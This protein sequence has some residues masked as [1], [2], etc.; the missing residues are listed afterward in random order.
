MKKGRHALGRLSRGQHQEEHF[1]RQQQQR[2]DRASINNESTNA[3]SSSPSRPDASG[4]GRSAYLSHSLCTEASSYCRHPGRPSPGQPNQ[5]SPQTKHCA[6]KR[7]IHRHCHCIVA[8]CQ[9]LYSVRLPV[10]FLFTLALSAEPMRKL[11]WPSQQVPQRT[12]ISHLVSP[13]SSLDSRILDSQ[14]SIPSTRSVLY[15]PDSAPS[16]T[17]RVVV[18]ISNFCVNCA[19]PT[20]LVAR[21]SSD[22]SRVS[23]EH[24]FDTAHYF[25]PDRCHHC[26]ARGFSK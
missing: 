22:K 24:N 23:S 21:T 19:K 15:Q 4:V 8:Y 5:L 20:L 1:L 7:R 12:I 2:P 17:L 11:M 13:S 16:P 18:A 26:G 3:A 6:P 25:A 14:D 9:D 10:H